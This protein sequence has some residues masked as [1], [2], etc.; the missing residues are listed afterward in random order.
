[1]DDQR[2]AAE[3]VAADMRAEIAARRTA[4]GIGRALAVAAERHVRRDGSC[5]CSYCR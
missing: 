1:M 4:E 5:T 2:K 3:R